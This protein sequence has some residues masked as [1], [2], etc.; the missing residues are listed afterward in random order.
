MISTTKNIFFVVETV[1]SA[2]ETIV[3][4]TENI[5]PVPHTTFFATDTIFSVSQKTAGEAP[6]VLF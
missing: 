4:G 2:A 6:A 5:F 1:I 3:S